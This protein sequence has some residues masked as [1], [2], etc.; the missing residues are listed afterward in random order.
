[1]SPRCH[2][3]RLVHTSSSNSST[4]TPNHVALW[5][6]LTSGLFQFG[7]RFNGMYRDGKSAVNGQSK[8]ADLMASNV[9]VE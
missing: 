4:T 1:M 2:R 6:G 7:I 8:R 5:L 9:T 3:S